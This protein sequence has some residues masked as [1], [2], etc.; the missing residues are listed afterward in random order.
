MTPIQATANNLGS[1]STGVAGID[2]V[3]ML[4][5]DGFDLGQERIEVDSANAA[6]SPQ[7]HAVETISVASSACG[8]PGSS[9]VS[10]QRG[11][12]YPGFSL[13]RSVGEVRSDSLNPGHSGQSGRST[14][15]GQIQQASHSRHRQVRWP[16]PVHFTHG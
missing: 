16:D 3:R 14:Q 6:P 2:Q 4:C 13:R 15:A 10:V 5:R 12:T 8:S 7:M 1:A 11:S 9:I